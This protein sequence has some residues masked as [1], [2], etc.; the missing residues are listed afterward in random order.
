MRLACGVFEEE[1]NVVWPEL[2]RGLETWLVENDAELEAT[3][4]DV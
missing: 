3:K 4:D 1:Y 2:L